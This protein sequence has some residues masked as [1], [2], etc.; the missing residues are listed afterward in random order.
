MNDISVFS[1]ELELIKCERIRKCAERALLSCDA[2]FFTMPASTSGKYHPL[3]SLGEGGLVRHTRAVVYF[4]V[5][6]WRSQLFDVIEDE[7]D[8]LILGAIIHDIKKAG[9]SGSQHTVKEHPQLAAQFIRE[10]NEYSTLDAVLTS[11]ELDYVCKA[12]ESHMG[13][14]G[15]PVPQTD[16]EKLLH[17]AD[18]CASRKEIDIKFISEGVSVETERHSVN[19]S[20]TT[21]SD[22]DLPNY[23]I[24]F[25][26]YKGKKLSEVPED[27]IDWCL[28]NL[29]PTFSVMDVFKRYKETKK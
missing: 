19:E 10:C 28:K 11:A 20:K 22:D 5:E 21:V 13:V 7:L 9:N 3:F 2:Y 12:V 23:S 6:L 29:D 17:L 25:G 14:W 27:Y 16:A 15:S 8:L 4:L 1:H 26:K 24:P 18:L